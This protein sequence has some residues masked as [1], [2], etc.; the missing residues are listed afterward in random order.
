MTLHQLSP[1]LELLH[2]YFYPSNVWENQRTM[3]YDH[4]LSM[5]EFWLTKWWWWGSNVVEESTTFIINP[6]KKNGV[7]VL[8]CEYWIWGTMASFLMPFASMISSKKLP[9]CRTDLLR[10]LS[11]NLLA[12]FLLRNRCNRL[13]GMRAWKMQP[14]MRRRGEFPVT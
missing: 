1:I 8:W 2:N 5:H 10:W 13:S 3:K 12:I 4:S 9:A 7:I 11:F 14:K 6:H